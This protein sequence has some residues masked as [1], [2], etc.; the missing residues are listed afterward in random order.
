MEIQQKDN[1]TPAAYIHCFKTAAKWCAFDN[2][3]VA[4][5]IFIKGLWDVHTT[6][7]EIYKKGP[8]NCVWCHKIC[9]KLNAAQN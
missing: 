9:W 3:T 1:E 7:A 2:D 8:P 4:N 5:H 6:A